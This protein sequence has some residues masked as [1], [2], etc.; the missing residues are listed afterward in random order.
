[1][2]H[3]LI[4][5]FCR[6]PRVLA[7]ALIIIGLMLSQFIAPNHEIKAA[8]FTVTN[9]DDAG[10]GSLRQAILDANSSA[11]ADTITFS[12]TGTITLA[13]NLPTITGDLTITGPGVSN[14]TIVGDDVVNDP[15]GTDPNDLLRSGFI[16]QTGR[17]VNVSG[18]RLLNGYGDRGGAIQNLG[19]VNLSNCLITSGK[20]RYE[21]G[22]IYNAPGAIA[23]IN[24]CEVNTNNLE[25]NS[26]PG[27]GISN[28]GTMTITNSTFSGN[29]SARGGAIYNEG[30]LT[31]T[32]STFS[33]NDAS[34]VM[35]VGA[36][37]GLYN[38]GGAVQIN[39]TTFSANKS[40]TGADLG[41]AIHVVGGSVTVT[42]SIVANS[43]NGDNCHGTIINGGYNVEYPGTSCGFS[44]QVDPLLGPLTSNGGTT[45][46]HAL[47][48]GSSAIDTVP[49][50][51]CTVT[52]D[53]RNVT[54]PIDGDGN[55]T[56]DCDS[57]SYEAPV[58]VAP[59]FSITDVSALETN[60]ATTFTFTVTRSSAAA[61][62]STVNYATADGTATA[63]SNDYVAQS[64][65]LTFASGVTTQ[66]VQIT[67][68]G[69][70]AAESD[71]TF[72]VNLSNSSWASIADNQGLGTIQNDDLA[73]VTVTQTGGSTAVTE[74]GATDSFNVVLV[75][76]PSAGAVT[77]SALPDAQCDLGA[78][79]GVAVT[80]DFDASNWNIP[81][82]V[83]V[84]AV[85]DSIVEGPHS[86]LITNSIA[87]SGA[88][89]YALLP[90]DDV[91]AAI[92]DN[93]TAGVIVTESD[94]T[95]AV[96]E[97]GAT[98]TF[99]IV[100]LS[101]P[102]AGTVTINATPD[103]QCDLGAGAGVAV[104][105]DFNTGNWNTAWIVTVAAYN[106]ALVEGL[107]SCLITNA[108]T[109]SGAIEYTTSTAVAD[110]TAAITDNDTASA[111]VSES[112]GNTA[113]AEGAGTDTFSIVLTSQPS[114]GI[115]TLSASPDAQ[116]DLGAGPGVAVTHDFDATTWNTAWI[117]TV[118]AYNDTLVEGP[119]SCLITNSITASGAAE[120]P[121]SMDVADVTAAITDNDTAGVIVTESDGSTAVAE[122]GIA[123][124]FSIVL[125]SQPSAGTV[126][127]SATPNAQ[128]DLGAGA[129]VAISHN[130]GSADWNT[131]WTITVAAYNDTVVEGLHSCLITN[132][133]TASGA[134]EYPT[135]MDVADVTAAITD[136]DTAGVV[137]T[138]SG[139]S[140]A[141]TEGGATDSFTIA[142][143]SQPS[144]GTVT[145]SATPDAQCDLGA[146]A[147]VAISH[148]FGSADWNTPWT[149]TV[150]AV[151]DLLM[152][153]PHSCLITNDITAS[154]AAEYPASMGV[155]DITA[156][157]TDNESAGV[158]VTESDG[159]TDVTEGGATDTFTI[160]LNSQP[161]AGTVT[162][163]ATPD[164]QCNLGAGA[165]VA[166]SHD[167]NA[168]DWNTG[169]TVTV[170]AVDDDVAEGPHTCLIANDIT[171]SGAVE[172]PVGLAVADVTA[173]INDNETQSID[174][175]PQS[176]TISEPNGSVPFT[177]RLMT[178]PT[179][180]VQID[181]S[182]SDTTEC[183][184]TVNMV[185]LT[186][187]NWNTGVQVEVSA[188]DDDLQDGAQT[189]MV[190]TAAA[191]STDP[192]YSGIDPANVRVTVKDNDGGVDVYQPTAEDI[193]RSQAPLCADMDGT[194]NPV[195][196][197]TVPSGAVSDG[198]VFC[199]V[200]AENSVFVR[201]SA[202]VGELSVLQRGVIQAV[203]VFGLTH[204]GYGI[205]E[206]NLDVNICLQGTGAFIYLDATTFPRTAHELPV[207]LQGG[208][209]CASI[210][211]AGTVVLVQGIPTATTLPDTSAS[212][213]SL[214]DCMVITK[215]IMNLRA[216]PSATSAVIVQ[217][218]YDVTLTAFQRQADWF[219][220]DFVGTRGWLNSGF[221]TLSGACGQ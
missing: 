203:D 95:T 218:P 58:V 41:A 97:G 21:G 57:G 88:P 3:Q 51:S 157:I 207:S 40:G 86:C 72:F 102:S 179:A 69:D 103:A 108:I 104:S 181:L 219:Y 199:R 119:H 192:I 47:T 148:N 128:C 121:T 178:E 154:G 212:N 173:T 115:I 56:P 107:H 113:V 7:L 70:W 215:A 48:I 68:N 32:N 209:T 10:P 200:L 182:V 221:V 36:G 59:S 206:F 17:T 153:G 210:P 141:V 1:M 26:R 156:A 190:V 126:T 99:S 33:G 93:D 208:Y 42:A 6:L 77:V 132:S 110:V 205:S 114:A 127:V 180:A 79:P 116:C 174:V 25:V 85:N 20:G 23:T 169:W 151:N 117:V 142:L 175:Q 172:Y 18:I 101:Q 92:T 65:T 147:G 106:D 64:G 54:R 78:G 2:Q 46:N 63:A 71:E 87:A 35:A 130:F 217:V 120:Y 183:A 4:R 8:T 159:N 100:L 197:A 22:G 67:V 155:A 80:H 34:V 171:A 184:L 166:V 11:G 38:A 124:T 139:G 125:T 135:S 31:I 167:F 177:I 144:A 187:A 165:G 82:S 161:T 122:G 43:I 145:V 188:L 216:E 27:A 55:G 198:S 44:I 94:G 53:Q 193:A 89:E 194:T 211:D 137:V 118:A 168:A 90:V 195:V 28:Y 96:T 98:D 213:R 129:G 49:A 111:A 201:T 50:A 143:I 62:Q 37:A 61:F 75:Y 202:E 73:G 5:S 123:D 66:N 109:A 152:E 176:L 76:Q 12:V 19:T 39:H 163:S 45:R 204:N 15:T 52:R 170:A 134:A 189:C 14:L 30:L 220:V 105:H 136:N 140:T 81:W 186:A 149:I 74:D 191:V 16:I 24:N 84:A 112:G 29:N 164:A 196:R 9:L 158:T 160:V 185:L 131:P 162:V 83:P 13:T 91:P 150:T 138:E 133:I 214:S 146:G 60:A